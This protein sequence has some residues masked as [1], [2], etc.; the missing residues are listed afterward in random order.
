MIVVPNFEDNQFSTYKV[1]ANDSKKK[2][3]TVTV[4]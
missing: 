4:K 3:E 2:S 1:V